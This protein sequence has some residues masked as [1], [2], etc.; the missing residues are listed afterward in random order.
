MNEKE[1][2]N[3]ILQEIILNLKNTPENLRE[4]FFY[5]YKYDEFTYK[6]IEN[7]FEMSVIKNLEEQEFLIFDEGHKNIY[8]AINKN[9]P[10]INQAIT[11]IDRLKEFIENCSPE[12]HEV[13]TN[14][15]SLNLS[16]TNSRFWNKFILDPDYFRAWGRKEPKPAFE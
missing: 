14:K 16:I 4:L 1:K 12:F 6:T 10:L 5:H 2:F 7:R 9:D 8:I 13:F 3:S 15:T 11:S